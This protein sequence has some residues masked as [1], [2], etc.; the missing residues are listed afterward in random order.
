MPGNKLSSFR[1]RLAVPDEG[2]RTK[3]V[4]SFRIALIIPIIWRKIAGFFRLRLLT[5]KM[6]CE[7]SS[8]L[9]SPKGSEDAEVFFWG[10]NTFFF[11]GVDSNFL[12]KE[13]NKYAIFDS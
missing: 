7:K 9:L 11:L 13:S 5:S 3:Y 6:T 4:Y 10:S 8:L 2:I 12:F 1:G